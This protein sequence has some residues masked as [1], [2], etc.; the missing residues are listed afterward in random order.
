MNNFHNYFS[1]LERK[2]AKKIK[3]ETGPD[4]SNEQ[5]PSN[6]DNVDGQNVGKL[7]GFGGQS[8]D[9]P[10]EKIGQFNSDL[11]DENDR[12]SSE[13][14]DQSSCGSGDENGGKPS[15]EDED[16]QS[17]SESCDENDKE[18][19][20]NDDQ[21]NSESGDGNDEDLSDR[22]CASCGKVY[23]KRANLNAHIKA[24]HSGAKYFCPVE[25]CGVDTTTKGSLLRH[26]RIKHRK[27]SQ[28][29][30]SKVSEHSFLVGDDG[31]YITT[32]EAKFAKIKRLERD[33]LTKNDEIAS[34]KLQ[35]EK[36]KK[37][38]ERQVKKI[39]QLKKNDY[40]SKL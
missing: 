34:L 1:Q 16:D 21:S 4:Q 20:E 40:V 22:T 39:A 6:E 8:D 10:S 2:R 32:H 27:V 37:V 24:K 13:N 7:S 25:G 35:I 36:L 15:G 26:I 3:T 19:S 9:M 5:T 30:I 12:E 28:A 31:N 14:D 33:L 38:N 11:G 23:S 29:H 18:S 17:I